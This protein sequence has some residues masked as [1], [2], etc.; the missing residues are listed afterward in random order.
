MVEEGFT[1]QEDKIQGAQLML[2]RLAQNKKAKT[3]N[4]QNILGMSSR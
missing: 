3:T 1:A 2:K 4:L